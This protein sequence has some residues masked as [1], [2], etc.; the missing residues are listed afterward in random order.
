M[1]EGLFFFGQRRLEVVCVREYEVTF[2]WVGKGERPVYLDTEYGFGMNPPIV[3]FGRDKKEALRTLK[4]PG[5]VKVR[6]IKCTGS[7]FF[8][9]GA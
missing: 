5:S 7:R 6:A 9:S 8:C 4:L 2:E 3:V 1:R